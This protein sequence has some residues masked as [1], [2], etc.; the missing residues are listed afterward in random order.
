MREVSKVAEKRATS[1][2]TPSTHRAARAQ[3]VRDREQSQATLP[4]AHDRGSSA[5]YKEVPTLAE[6]AP[7][8]IEGYSKANG[9]KPSTITCKDCQLRVHLLPVFGDKRLDAIT[10]EDVQ[11]FKASRSHLSTKTINNILWL[12]RSAA[13]TGR[14]SICVGD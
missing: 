12:V 10:S 11:R 13:C 8:Y 1:S 4:A 7:R 9:H 3:S 6:F 14:R 2:H 5:S